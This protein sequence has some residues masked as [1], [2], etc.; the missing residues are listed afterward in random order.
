MLL[1]GYDAPRDP[2]GD[3]PIDW[4]EPSRAHSGIERLGSRGGTSSRPHDVTK[5]ERTVLNTIADFASLAL[6]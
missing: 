6:Q 1:D 5:L 2:V 3:E 4:N